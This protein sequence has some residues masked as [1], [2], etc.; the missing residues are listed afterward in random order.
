[1]NSI[2]TLEIISLILLTVAIVFL[3]KQYTN[4]GHL[5]QFLGKLRK[6]RG[7]HAPQQ[8]MPQM[9]ALLDNA[10]RSLNCETSWIDEQSDRVVS[11]QYQNGHCCHS[12]TI[13]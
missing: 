4:I 3:L 10:L 9:E 8:G 11:Y 13:I 2:L 5:N 12:N 7:K 1:M 6:P